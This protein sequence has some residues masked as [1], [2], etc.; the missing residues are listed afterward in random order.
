MNSNSSKDSN[1]NT[2]VI[3]NNN[4]YEYSEMRIRMHFNTNTE[5]EYSIPGYACTTRHC[6][7]Y[8]D[9]LYM[10]YCLVTVLVDTS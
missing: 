9:I 2:A 10:V 8:C 3:A 6:T 1:R 4:V 7:D 5:Y